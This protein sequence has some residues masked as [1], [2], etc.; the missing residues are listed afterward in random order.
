MQGTLARKVALAAT[1]AATGAA[2]RYTSAIPIVPGVVEFTPSMAIPA[3]AGML[4]G[5]SGGVTV[6][7]A[8]GLSGALR[9]FPPIPIV[10]NVMLGL[11]PGIVKEFLSRRR[12]TRL[13]SSKILEWIFY[14]SVISI[15]GGFLPTFAITLMFLYSTPWGAVLLGSFD[16]ANA[17]LA[18]VAA[19]I[20]AEAARGVTGFFTE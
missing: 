18:G 1:L 19:L 12:E 13:N 11:G 8:V 9:E 17:A 14:I 20:V 15:V 4:L 5:V 2:L 3:L 10:G 6:G 7:F 16:A